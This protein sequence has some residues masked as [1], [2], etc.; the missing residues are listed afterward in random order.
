MRVDPAYIA[1]DLKI[2]HGD[3]LEYPTPEE[4]YILVGNIPFHLSG[5]I[6][7]RF[8]SEEKYKTLCNGLYN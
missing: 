7:R 4:D 8:M 1:E 3:I 5:Q 6:Y 2:V